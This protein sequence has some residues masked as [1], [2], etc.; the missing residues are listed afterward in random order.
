MEYSPRRSMCRSHS[1]EKEQSRTRYTS[2][3]GKPTY[4]G[5]EAPVYGSDFGTGWAGGEGV[6][7]GGGAIGPASPLLARSA[8]ACAMAGAPN[9]MKHPRT[10]RIP[11]LTLRCPRSISKPRPAIASTAMDVASGPVIRLATHCTAPGRAEP[12]DCGG[13]KVRRSM[14]RETIARAVACNPCQALITPVKLNTSGQLPS[15]A[16][17]RWAR[18]RHGAAW[19]ARLPRRRESASTASPPSSWASR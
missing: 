10:T 2:E 4:I 15:A 11:F 12:D 1:G 9:R 13:A 16:E 6:V 14:R 19:N 17:G 8:S 18:T 5:T 3:P 7:T